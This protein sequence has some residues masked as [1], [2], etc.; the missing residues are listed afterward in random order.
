CTLLVIPPGLKSPYSRG[1]G[2]HTPCAREADQGSSPS[3][4]TTVR[5]SRSACFRGSSVL[6]RLARLQARTRTPQVLKPAR[7]R[8]RSK[9]PRDPRRT[10]R[11]ERSSRL[12]LF[13]ISGGGRLRR[14]RASCTVAR[15]RLWSSQNRALV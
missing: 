13:S 6:R 7:H 1:F 3:G 5:P 15:A 11:P 10:G 9:R 12:T 4:G 14:G 8:G 2:A